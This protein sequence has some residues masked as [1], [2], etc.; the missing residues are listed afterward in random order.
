MDARFQM[1]L[2]SNLLQVW[3]LRSGAGNFQAEGGLELQHAGTRP[4]KDIDS[5]E[6]M[7]PSN[8]QRRS[9]DIRSSERKTLQVDAVMQHGE[10]GGRDAIL[11]RLLRTIV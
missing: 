9:V 8:C 1:Q 6:R 7:Q 2:L 11:H 5:L 10:L 4:E 3:P